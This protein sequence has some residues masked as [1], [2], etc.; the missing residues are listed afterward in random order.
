MQI[1]IS[2]AEAN[3]EIV[4]NL[5]SKFNLSTE[6]IIARIALSYSL[7]RNRKLNLEDVKDAKGKTYKENTL[8]GDKRDF[9]VAM[10][11]QHY[12][13]YQNDANIGKYVKMHVDDGL[14]MISKFFEN[15]PNH[16]G[17]DFLIEN[18][19]RGI[20][21]IE[22]AEVTFDPVANNNPSVKDK[23]YFTG[24]L[25]ILV[26]KDIN[27]QED[28]YLHPNDTNTYNNCHIA[29][30]GSSGTGKTQF[31]LT[32][33]DQIVE[34]SQGQVNYV[35]LDF[36]GLKKD[37]K[38]FLQ[39]FFTKTKTTLIDAPHTP[40]PVNPLSF[41]DTINEKNRIMGINKFVDIISHYANLG[42]NQEQTLKDATR[43]VF[44]T[45]EPGTYPSFQQI[46]KAVLDITGDDTSKLREI[47]E[48][49]GE[50][51]LFAT[52]V[53]QNF[54]DGN[55]YLSLSGDLPDNV[56]FTS[57]FLVINYIYNV[58]M[59]MENTPV[60]D[61]VRAMRYVFL[62]DEAHVIFREKKSQDLLD[63]LLREIRSKGVSIVLLSQGIEEFNQP[64]FDFS[65][66]CEI[67]I[68]LSIKNKNI[69]LINK[70]MGFGEGDASRVARSMEK[71]EPGQAISNIKEFKRGE[72]FQ[73]NQFV[74]A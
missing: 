36:K 40:F 29:A 27:T 72:L 15:N 64:S 1:N 30:A 58:F 23:N 14:E 9:F 42:K 51:E 21:A 26:G 54:L 20:E 34:K 74:N 56:R 70:F 62:I 19:D 67:A 65:S 5:T 3:Q 47:L 71:I 16:D 59:N 6:N 61:G 43:E 28:I 73:I 49:L 4:T 33:L 38:K 31:A 18:I 69:R 41:I 57:V 24:L 68:L 12:G 63:K 44:D 11:C 32:L 2:T 7:S 22:T 52:E 50:L 10:V 17:F 60:E 48:S 53:D 55:Y 66:N 13:I 25:K 8:F 37:D 35:Y 39:P 45:I 46:Y